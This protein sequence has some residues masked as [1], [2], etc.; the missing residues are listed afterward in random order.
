MSNFPN[1]LDVSSDQRSLSKD[2]LLY[3]L[4]VL[5]LPGLLWSSLI[6]MNIPKIY[7]IF[8]CFVL[9]IHL[10]TR[11]K[12]RHSIS[13][14]PRGRSPKTLQT[15]AAKMAGKVNSNEQKTVTAIDV[16]W[17]TW[18]TSTDLTPEVQSSDI[19][20]AA[21]Q[22]GGV[23]FTAE[24]ERTLLLKDLLPLSFCT[25]LEYPEIRVFSSWNWLLWKLVKSLKSK[26][27]H[28]NYWIRWS[29]EN[30]RKLYRPDIGSWPSRLANVFFPLIIL[31]SHGWPSQGMSTWVR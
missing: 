1:K 26:D 2:E 3:C 8:R 23:I 15:M 27:M 20:V 22:R 28:D 18:E 25:P 19:F 5:W 16:E 21:R 7:N 13:K 11:Q 9:Q 29:H 6:L 31:E 17:E 24:M 4:H 10:A 14:P 30:R 12:T